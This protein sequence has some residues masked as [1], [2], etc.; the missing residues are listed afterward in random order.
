MYEC[1]YVCISCAIMLEV[2]LIDL[3]VE[4]SEKESTGILLAF[5]LLMHH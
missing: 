4:Y 2:E 5:L 1:M 3:G